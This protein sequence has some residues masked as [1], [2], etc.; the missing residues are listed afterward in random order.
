MREASIRQANVRGMVA[1]VNVYW[2]R[3][4]E[5]GASVLASIGNRE[6]G[7]RDIT[8]PDPD[9]FEIRFGSRLQSSE[10]AC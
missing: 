10:P 2:Q 5:M 9:R 4:P 3:A 1:D 8:I 6:Y 7:L